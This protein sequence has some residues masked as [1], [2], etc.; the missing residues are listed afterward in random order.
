MKD[1]TATKKNTKLDSAAL[2]NLG[3]GIP[4]IGEKAVFVCQHSSSFGWQAA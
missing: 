4:P 2:H 1:T 3:R